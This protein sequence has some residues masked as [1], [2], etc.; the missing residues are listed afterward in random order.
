MAMSVEGL[1]F[2]DA[3]EGDPLVEGSVEATFVLAGEPTAFVPVFTLVD[4]PGESV[5]PDFLRTGAAGLLGIIN[6]A[7]KV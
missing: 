1:R 6:L 7:L 4:V 5:D 3:F 2:L